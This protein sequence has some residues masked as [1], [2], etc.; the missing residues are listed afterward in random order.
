MAPLAARCHL[1]LGRVL[2][3]AQS[4]E[5]DRH[6]RIADEMIET[7]GLGRIGAPVL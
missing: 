1:R 3:A 4:S 5:A 7:L 2:S 6:S